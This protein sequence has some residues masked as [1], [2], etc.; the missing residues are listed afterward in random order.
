MTKGPWL[1]QIKHKHLS[2]LLNLVNTT[3]IIE[4]LLLTIELNCEQTIA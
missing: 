4:K 1:M 3:D 2:L